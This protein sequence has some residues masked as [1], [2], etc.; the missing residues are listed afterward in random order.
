MRKLSAKWVR[1]CLNAYQKRQRCQLSEQLLG[2][3]LY[4]RFK[5]FPVGRDWWPWTKPGYITMTQRQSTNQWSGGIIAHNPTPK[6]SE[7]K[8]PLE[9]FSPRFFGIKTAS[10]SLIIFQR[11]KP[12]TRCITH[13]CWCNWRTFLKEKRRGKFTKGVLFL[14]NNATAHRALATGLL[15]LPIFWSPNLFFGSGPV[16]LPLV[17][18]SV[19]Q[20]KVR[21]FS[22]D[23]DLVGGTP[24]WIF[25]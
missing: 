19:K 22:S 1:K 9:K 10:F 13:L 5:W 17:L 15:G 2:F 4:A 18:W 25:F 23:A 24:F 12:S 8:N 20:L 11:A 14:Y 7:C 21:H 16:G 6:N 3:F